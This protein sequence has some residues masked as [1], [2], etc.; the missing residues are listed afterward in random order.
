MTIDLDMLQ[1]AHNNATIEWKDLGFP[2][3]FWDWLKETYGV[4]VY[5][6]FSNR[7]IENYKISDE[8]KFFLF[9]VKHGS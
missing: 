2:S 3:I 4:E 6:D 9:M 8:H 5:F 7:K 1:T